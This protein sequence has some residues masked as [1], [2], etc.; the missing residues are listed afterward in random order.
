M[1]LYCGRTV[2]N[3]GSVMKAVYVVAAVL[4]V[5]GLLVVVEVVV[6]AVVGVAAVEAGRSRSRDDDSLVELVL[7]LTV[8]CTVLPTSRE[9]FLLTGAKL[10]LAGTTSGFAVV[11][12]VVLVVVV[13]GVAVLAAEWPGAVLSKASSS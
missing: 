9:C 5:V 7:D 3:T 8:L 2:E 12:V 1:L 6:E 13:E 4:S 11:V 10:L